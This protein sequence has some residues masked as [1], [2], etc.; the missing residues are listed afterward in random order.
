MATESFKSDVIPVSFGN[1][2]EAA[3]VIN[4]WVEDRTKH[5]IQKII[6]SGK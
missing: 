1:T 2:V 5:K 4:N 3:N 6:S